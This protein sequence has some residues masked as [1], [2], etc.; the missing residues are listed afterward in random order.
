MPVVVFDLD[1]TLYEEETFVRSGFRAVAEEL[2]LLLGL[3]KQLAFQYMW[4]EMKRSGRGQVFDRVLQEYGVYTRSRVNR[5]LSV[6]RSHKPDIRLYEDSVRFFQKHNG[7]P[8]YIVT[9]GNKLVQ[10]KKLESLGLYQNPKVRRSFISRRYG[11]HNEKPSVHCFEIIRRLE[12]ASPQEIVYVGD[13][14][15]KDFV[16]IKPL[17]YQTVRIMRGNFKNVNLD[18]KY[19]AEHRIVSLD[20]LMPTLHN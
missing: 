3:D 19:E 17:G 5:C 20:E 11:I 4:D 8:I 13:N 15:H 18:D 10:Q 6:Y 14:P 7:I 1:D 9:D 12:N 16:G 2:Q